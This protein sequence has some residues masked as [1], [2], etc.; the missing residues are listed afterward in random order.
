[1]DDGKD[2][3]KDDARGNG[4]VNVTDAAAESGSDDD[5]DTGLTAFVKDPSS[6]V[7]SVIAVIAAAVAGI[8][9]VRLRRTNKRIDEVAAA[10]GIEGGNP[11]SDD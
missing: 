9:A 1:K 5:E 3:G 4:K 10:A 8:M 2:D 11:G 6:M 7:P